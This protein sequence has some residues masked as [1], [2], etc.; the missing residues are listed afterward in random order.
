MGRVNQVKLPNNTTYDIYGK[1]VV[2][3]SYDDYQN[4]SEE[5]KNA[6]IAYHIYNVPEERA[7]PT[8]TVSGS[9]VSFDDGS[10]QPLKSLKLSIN[11]VQEGSGTPSPQNVRPLHG[12]TG[13]YIAR[14][15]SKNF[16][17]PKIIK[18][19]T[20]NA[21]VGTQFT[22]SEHPYSYSVSGDSITYDVAAWQ[23]AGFLTMPLQAG[24][25]T[26]QV[27]QTINS[28]RI[29]VYTLDSDNKVIS[30]YASTS[31]S[32]N[33]RTITVEE[34]GHRIGIALTSNTAQTITLIN[35]MLA[36]GSTTSEYEPYN[37]LST[38]YPITW[39]EAGEVFGG[40]IECS[41][42]VWGAKRTQ[43]KLDV[44]DFSISDLNSGNVNQTTG[45]IRYI[46][47]VISDKAM[48]R[49]D[50]MCN[51]FPTKATT[52]YDTDTTETISG[53]TG[54]KAIYIVIDSN[55]LS[56]DLTTKEGRATAL[57]N[58]IAN[59]PMYIVY[60]LDEPTP[61]TLDEPLPTITTLL[62]NNNIWSD[63]GEVLECVYVPSLLTQIRYN[64]KVYATP[65]YAPKAG[66]ANT[67]SG[68]TVGLDIPTPTSEDENKYLKGDG[69][70]AEV[71]GGA[72][73][74]ELTQA[75]YDALSPAEK[76]NGKMYFITDG[77]ADTA[78]GGEPFK[79][80]NLWKNTNGAGVGTYTLNESIDNYDFIA[81]RYGK[82]DDYAGAT[83]LCDYRILSVK[84]LQAMHDEGI[85]VVF[86]GYES[87][88]AYCDFNDDVMQVTFIN[89]NQLILQVDGIKIGSGGSGG[90]SEVHYST[91]EQVVGTW[92]DGSTV[93]EKI[94]DLG[95]ETI[96]SAGWHLLSIP[97][98]NINRIFDGLFIS[99]TGVS[100]NVGL[101]C[102]DTT[103]IEILVYS[104]ASQVTGRYVRARYT[105][106]TT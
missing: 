41:D 35:A 7:E 6:D 81:V 59:N 102:N 23:G 106:S 52:G 46:T 97:K 27:N 37:P 16:L 21:S 38:T 13:A 4:L 55:R 14:I 70:W 12:W 101:A 15:G 54:N 105:K 42:L 103:Y 60:N 63:T 80:T 24:T 1:N 74:V 5:Q 25:Y 57:L 51:I 68:H 22:F 44:S 8:N 76:M 66:D 91:D 83:P 48:G 40:E 98:A 78:S 30:A 94:F 9:I 36:V 82:W 56:G 29:S 20:Y 90:S 28:P 45:M 77:N 58:W 18:G 89:G 71:G 93:Y 84:D 100:Y 49:A 3:I 11:P 95:S 47:S 33:N 86:T 96:Y 17:E 26:F 79:E 2:D 50:M 92:I 87:R 85:Y 31:A 61:I 67:V 73:Y 104:G 43:G 19:Y 34:N 69:T 65:S 32:F 99:D 72:S 39:S 75:E 10:A 53:N 64:E 88:V 62:G